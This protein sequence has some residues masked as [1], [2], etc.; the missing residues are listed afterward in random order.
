MIKI[1]FFLCSCCES[2]KLLPGKYLETVCGSPFYMAP[3]VLQFQRYN[4]K[5]RL[6]YIESLGVQDGKR[7]RLIGNIVG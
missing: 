3:E 4:E 5:V 6:W 2:R 7:W 1:L